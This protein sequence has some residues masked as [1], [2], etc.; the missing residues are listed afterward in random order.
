MMVRVKQQLG[1]IFL[2]YLRILAKFQLAK[3][4][5]WRRIKGK[6]SVVIVGIT[7]S[8]GK[9]STMYATVAALR[10]SFRV[11]YSEKANSE[12]GIPLNILGLSMKDYSLKDWLRVA[13]L[14]PLKL[15]TNWRDYDVYAAEMGVDEPKEPKNMSYLLKIIRPQIGVFIGVTS[16]HSQQ[17]E[18]AGFEDPVRA[19]AEEKGRLLA[20]LPANGWAIVN[21]D[22]RLVWE[23]AKRSE[24]KIIPVGRH[25]QAKLRVIRYSVSEIGTKITYSWRKRRYCLEL[26]N[27]VLPPVYSHTFGFALA[28]ALTQQI[29]LKKAIAMISRNFQL[30]PGRSSLIKGIKNTLIIDSS[31]NASPLAMITML[32]LLGQLGKKTGRKKIAVLG[33]MRELG[34]QSKKEHQ[35]IARKAIKVA[36]Q[37]VLVGPQM[38][39][40]FLPAALEMGFDQ[41]K[42][43]SFL[44]AG[45]AARFLKRNLQGGELILVK[46]SQNTIF[47]EIVVEALMKDKSK[48][49][50][51]LCRR[52]KFWDQ[53]RKNDCR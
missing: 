13:V 42:I 37:I 52:G 32:D 40:Y 29:R 20:A 53:K 19:I 47:L 18:Q 23:Q 41:K 48:A 24:A 8:A 46:G 3:I 28:V 31:Y 4:N 14:S 10:D 51:L 38:R 25:H 17:F 36:D 34:N 44:K 12:S 15:L 2:H 39:E 50:Q 11:K 22:D 27:Y 26:A 45:Q 30:P 49:E 33:D 5:F 1:L 6:R 16:V 7:G 9:T 35:R 43:K 21:R